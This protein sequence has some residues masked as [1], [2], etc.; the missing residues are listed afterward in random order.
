MTRKENNVT[1]YPGKLETYIFIDYENDEIVICTN[2]YKIIKECMINN[3]V[4][5]AKEEY[6]PNKRWFL[7]AQY[8][9]DPENGKTI[10]EIPHVRFAWKYTKTGKISYA[11]FGCKMSE[12]DAKSGMLKWIKKTSKKTT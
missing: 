11:I 4:W 12:N 3:A 6:V 5:Y 8:K 10:K 7:P 1:A 2:E 9:V